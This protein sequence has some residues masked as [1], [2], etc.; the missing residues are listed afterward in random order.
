MP[1][2]PAECRTILEA[3]ARAL[4]AVVQYKP[5]SDVALALDPEALPEA[6]RAVGAL[7]VGIHGEPGRER[8]KMKPASEIVDIGRA[9]Q[10]TGYTRGHLRRLL[11]AGTLRNVGTPD[12][13]AFHI[14]DLPRKPGHASPRPRLAPSSPPLSSSRVQ[15]ARAVVSGD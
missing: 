2:S 5:G 11:L 4:E 15:V 10:L 14:S 8:M 7:G 6:R 3:F 13:P 1:L 9:V 12:S